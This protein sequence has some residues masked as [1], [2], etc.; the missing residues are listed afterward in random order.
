M[1][2][3]KNNTRPPQRAARPKLAASIILLDGEPGNERVVMGAR[4]KALKFMPGAVVF[5]GGRV[6]KND[7]KI[8]CVD[9]LDDITQNKLISN[10]SGRPVQ[11]TARSLAVA[12]VR[13]LGE[14]TGLLIGG[15]THTPPQ[16][17]DW[18]P[19]RS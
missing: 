4:N 18:E 3:V 14:E 1:S 9:S 8:S 19:F 15:E 2:T 16:H 11:Q 17:D 5:P 7:G 12:A 13:E 10:M 6:D